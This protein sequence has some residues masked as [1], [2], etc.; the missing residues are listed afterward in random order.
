LNYRSEQLETIK[1]KLR[2][3]QKHASEVREKAKTQNANTSACSEK[4]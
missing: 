1:E 3:H 2:E 4:I